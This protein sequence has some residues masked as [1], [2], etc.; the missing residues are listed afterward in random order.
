MKLS[1]VVKDIIVKAKEVNY[2]HLDSNFVKY[3]RSM[4]YTIEELT[5]CFNFGNSAKTTYVF[6][7]STLVVKFGEDEM[8]TTLHNRKVRKCNVL[9]LNSIKKSNESIR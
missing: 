2:N 3:L 8:K 9:R 7:D 6:D 1:T 4:G 5:Y